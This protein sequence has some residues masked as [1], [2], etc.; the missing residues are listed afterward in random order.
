MRDQCHLPS[1][2]VIS[3]FVA[4]PQT[5]SSASSPG[6][7]PAEPCESGSPDGLPRF[8]MSFPHATH[9]GLC[10]S[11]E[12]PDEALLASRGDSNAT[13]QGHRHRPV[14]WSAGPRSWQSDTVASPPIPSTMRSSECTRCTAGTAVSELTAHCFTLT[15]RSWTPTVF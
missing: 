14:T 12:A 10:R 8:Y 5:D 4:L 6:R 13:T 15:I 2:R 7:W 1:C 3:A 9:Q 11:Q